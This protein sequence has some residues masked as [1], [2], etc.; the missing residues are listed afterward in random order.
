MAG[1]SVVKNRSLTRL[2]IHLFKL[3]MTRPR[4]ELSGIFEKKLYI[5]SMQLLTSDTQMAQRFYVL[6]LFIDVLYHNK[7]GTLITCSINTSLRFSYQLSEYFQIT[8]MT[9]L[10]CLLKYGSSLQI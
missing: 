9:Y 8:H 1:N 7:R 4:I 6:S 2:L 5:F 3:T 10:M